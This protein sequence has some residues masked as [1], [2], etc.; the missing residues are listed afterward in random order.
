MTTYQ[1]TAP[2]GITYTTEGPPGASPEQVRN[3]ILKAHPEAGKAP[4]PEAPERPGFF[5][6]FKDAASTLGALPE[7]TAYASNPSDDNRTALLEATKSKHGEGVGDFGKGENWEY[8]KELAGGSLGQMAAP[9]A[10]SWAAGLPFGAA[11]VGEGASVVGAP[12]IVPTLTAGTVASGS[13]FLGTSA[14]Q[15][16]IQGLA[17]QAK[18]QQDAIDR[19]Q[20]PED[21]NVG[22]AAVAGAGEG[23]LDMVEIGVLKHLVKA[24]PF[25]KPLIEKAGKGAEG[26]AEKLIAAAQQGTLKTVAGGITRG[27]VEGAAVEVPTEIAQQVL[28][29]WQAGLPLGDDDAIGEYKQAA[30]GALALTSIFGVPAGTIGA[31][32]TRNAARQ[33]L[34]GEDNKTDTNTSTDISTTNDDVKKRFEALSDAGKMLALKIQQD[35]GHT[36][37][38]SIYLAEQELGKHSGVEQE[39]QKQEEP[40]FSPE[41]TE[42]VN[43]LVALHGMDHEAAAATVLGLDTTVIPG[44]TKATDDVKAVRENVAATIDKLPE[45]PATPAPAPAPAPV[46]APATDQEVNPSNI[47]LSEPQAQRFQALVKSGI[48]PQDAFVQVLEREDTSDEPPPLGGV[49]AVDTSAAVPANNSASAPVVETVPLAPRKE[50]TATAKANILDIIDK[51]PEEYSVATPKQITQAATLAVQDE[52]PPEV[53]LRWV[54]NLMAPQ[55]GKGVG[56]PGLFGDLPE[57]ATPASVVVK[58]RGAAKPKVEAPLIFKHGIPDA[59][60]VEPETPAE[61]RARVLADRNRQ[62]DHAR[63]TAVDEEIDSLT[64]TAMEPMQDL[65]KSKREDAVNYMRNETSKYTDTPGIISLVMSLRG[66]DR[67]RL[68]Q[69]FKEE[70][71]TQDADIAELEKLI[72]DSKTIPQHPEINAMASLQSLLNKRKTDVKRLDL[73]K[74]DTIEDAGEWNL[75]QTL[76]ARVKDRKRTQIAPVGTPQERAVSYYASLKN[77]HEVESEW[78]KA[79]EAVGLHDNMPAWGANDTHEQLGLFSNLPETPK[80]KKTSNKVS[81]DTKEPIQEELAWLDDDFDSSTHVVDEF[82]RVQ[83]RAKKGVKYAIDK[84]TGELDPEADGTD[85]YVSND[86]LWDASAKPLEKEPKVLIRGRRAVQPST[87]L[88]VSPDIPT[89]A[90]DVFSD[91]PALVSDTA[92]IPAEDTSPSRLEPIEQH[93]KNLG[94]KV[95]FGDSKLGLIEGRNVVNGQPIYLPIVDGVL[96]RSDVDNTRYGGT[97][98]GDFVSAKN[99]ETLRAAKARLEAAEAQEHA[100]RPFVTFD[101]DGFS[102][103]SDMPARLAKTVAALKNLLLPGVNLYV[104]TIN[105]AR[106]NQDKFTGPLRGLVVPEEDVNDPKWGSSGYVGKNTFYVLYDPASPGLTLERI[107]HEMGHAHEISAFTNASPEMKAMLRAAHAKWLKSVQGKDTRGLINALRARET[108]GSTSVP[109]EL[110]AAERRNYW[111]SFSEWYADQVARWTTSASKPQSVIEKF[112]YRVAQSLRRFFARA[113]NKGWLPDDAFVRYMNNN[114]RDYTI[115]PS[116]ESVPGAVQYG[117][118]IGNETPKTMPEAEAQTDQA[119]E[120]MK[121]A[122]TA[123]SMTAAMREATLGHSADPVIASLEKKLQTLDPKVFKFTI[124][125][126]PSSTL[127][128]WLGGRIPQFKKGRDLLRLMLAERHNFMRSG[129]VLLQRYVDYNGAYGQKVMSALMSK[130]RLNSIDP[131]ATS[132]PVLAYLKTLPSTKKVSALIAKRQADI[133][134]IK[135]LWDE[136]GTHKGGQQLYLDVRRYYR[137]M[138]TLLKRRWLDNAMAQ[139]DNDA[140]KDEIKKAYENIEAEA[141]APRE[142]FYMGAPHPSAVEQYFPFKRFGDYVLRYSSRENENTG[143]P[144]YEYHRF[145]SQKKRDAKIKELLTRDGIKSTNLASIRNLVNTEFMPED[146]S[147]DPNNPSAVVSR[148]YDIIDKG[149]L[150]GA[151]PDTLKQEMKASLNEVLLAHLP[152]RSLGKNQMRAE[153]VPGFSMNFLKVLESSISQYSN[154]LPKIKYAPLIRAEMKMAKISAEKANPAISEKLKIAVDEMNKRFEDELNPKP[155]SWLVQGVNRFA[156]LML[157]TSGATAITQATSIPIRVM[158]NLGSR[159]G[160]G[161]AAATVGKFSNVLKTVRFTK[162]ENGKTVFTWPSMGNA[163]GV[164]GDAVSGRAYKTLLEHNVFND[165]PTSSFTDVKLTPLDIDTEPGIG[166]DAKRGVYKAYKVLTSGFAA[167][168]QLSRE[169][170]GMSAFTLA[171]NAKKAA[172]AKAGVKFDDAKAFEESIQDAIDT[173]NDTLGDYSEFERPSFMKNNAGRILFQFKQYAINTTKFFLENAYRSM[174]GETTAVKMQAMNELAGVLLIG[175]LFH[176]LLGQPLYSTIAATIDVVL[177]GLEDDDTKRKRRVRNP[178]TADDS[179][180][181]FRYEFMPEHFGNISVPGIGSRPPVTLSDMIM[182]GP[183]STMLDQNWG[184]KTS[185]NN[186]WLRSGQKGNSWAETT[187]NFILANLGPGVSAGTNMSGAMDDFDNGNY[188]RGLEKLSPALVK[189]TLQAVEHTDRGAT[190]SNG[191]VILKPT[192]F[193]DLHFVA[194]VLGVQPQRLSRLQDEKFNRTGESLEQTHTKNQVLNRLT[195]TL[196]QKHTKEDVKDALD[197]IRAYNKRYPRPGM[198]IDGDT[199]S[200]SIDAQIER[201]GLGL[202]GSYFKQDEADYILR[203]IRAA[204]S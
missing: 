93:A 107:A 79:L 28:E 19:G 45:P 52:V 46:T 189:G 60:Q 80:E 114:T 39:V 172:A 11:A 58:G 86:A 10:A 187:K 199:I 71:A 105:H 24:L 160:Y 137:N 57:T 152:A 196:F 140:D 116:V 111:E 126:L 53:A 121:T 94:G 77:R 49:P 7:A 5:G 87:D 36:L 181:R 158:P 35:E 198:V 27:I 167:M 48:A 108:A 193:D 162:Q 68:I 178:L 194:S 13:A 51:N 120:K 165:T 103:S 106:K 59:S 136:L 127:I 180:R 98:E 179:D 40:Q 161:P 192:D 112:F 34:A 75:M 138:Y 31:L 145:D 119:L 118:N 200:N 146:N 149:K 190:T 15:Y 123:V 109:R 163:P 151:N 185:F 23:A 38:D 17:R 153:N 82:G 14:S 156:H 125:K 169:I 133:D 41:Q 16:M 183:I 202:Y 186:M 50:R 147:Y 20:T 33:G 44:I 102:S 2:N 135:K 26:A 176:G 97:E 30:T 65:L 3:V 67:A 25:V 104:S 129:S 96:G 203:D 132:D 64:G 12:A 122:N 99:A 201:H 54:M 47:K 182:Y 18:Q 177:D 175:G 56:E 195:S 72:K 150:Q 83:A 81:S 110:T 173:I 148:L 171:Y 115:A 134:E 101:K 74:R 63:R 66:P 4:T 91:L 144:K 131:T 61:R 128:K 92:G 197:R 89:D 155:R 32:K 55:E 22:K 84:E 124:D 166:H 21:V 204:A 157:L 78:L 170:T 37:D 69:L 42:Q 164:M 88:L 130:A 113:K 70:V 142:D 85:A 139:V 6:S 141:G 191:D 154:Q 8:L 159:Y 168:E 29:R 117:S 143:G 100:L 90:A 62:L 174:A 76:G 95:V 184:S 9:I 43:Q 73:L 188:M 1:I